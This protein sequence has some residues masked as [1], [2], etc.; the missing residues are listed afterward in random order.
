MKPSFLQE[1]IQLGGDCPAVCAPHPRRGWALPGHL[2]Q[3]PRPTPGEFVQFDPELRNYMPDTSEEID[4]KEKIIVLNRVGT[5]RRSG[6]DS[7]RT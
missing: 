6:A 7:G 4:R 2:H 5:P 1:N 3:A